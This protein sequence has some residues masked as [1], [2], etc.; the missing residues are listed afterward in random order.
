MRW[1][2]NISLLMAMLMMLGVMEGVTAFVHALNF[3][4]GRNLLASFAD[5]WLI[6]FLTILSVAGALAASCNGVAFFR[7]RRGAPMSW[8]LHLW[9]GFF[10]LLYLPA[11]LFYLWMFGA[12]PAGPLAF[13]IVLTS[14]I[15]VAGIT[16]VYV[17]LLRRQRAFATA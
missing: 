8:A 3:D 5:L 6:L 13:F 1:G 11:A 2:V 9:N 10:L 14:C 7:Q 12:G 17:A 4:P 16:G 15:P